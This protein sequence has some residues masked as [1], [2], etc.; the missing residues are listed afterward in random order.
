MFAYFPH[1]TSVHS[2][3]GWPRQLFPP[4]G[5]QATLEPMMAFML[6][7]PLRA[8]AAW[9]VVRVIRP[10]EALASLESRQWE[11]VW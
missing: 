11:A 1:V 6:P 10:E 4:A 5:N 9:P 8:A 7:N 3:V 2:N